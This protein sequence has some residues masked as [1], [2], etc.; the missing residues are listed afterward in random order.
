MA[1]S[2]PYNYFDTPEG[3]DIFKKLWVV[4]KPTALTGIAISTVNVLCFPKKRT[5][6][7]LLGRYAYF[8]LPLVGIVSAFI[9]TTNL[10]VNYRHKDDKLNWTLGALAAGGIVG[11]WR[12]SVQAGSTACIAFTLAANV[13]KH[14][15]QNNWTLI[16]LE[17]KNAGMGALHGPRYDWTLTQERPRN[18]TRGQ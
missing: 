7:E 11:A 6:L 8:T 9:I 15:L 18:W 13:K 17:N 4:I 3:E 5:Y 10:A 2:K 14:C 16:P 12:R 1:E